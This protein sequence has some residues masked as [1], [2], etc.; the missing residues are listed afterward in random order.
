MKLLE[1]SEYHRV[2]GPLMEVKINNL[3]ARSVIEEKVNGIVYTD[4]SQKPRTFYITH[5]YGMSLLFGDTEN[6]TFNSGLIEHVLN[7]HGARTRPEWLQAFPETWNK[8][9]S[10]LFTNS[11]IKSKDILGSST[12]KKIEEHTRVNFKF[13]RQKY[14]DLRSAATPAGCRICRTDKDIFEKME[15]SVVPGYFWNDAESFLRHGVGF[16][17]IY[18]NIP[19]S[20]CFASFIH[21][22]K[23]ELGIETLGSCRGKGFAVCTCS[24]MIDYCLENNYEPIWSCRL[25]NNSSYILA[26][27][28]GFEPT[29][30]LPYYNLIV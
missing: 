17:L 3:F 21:D 13:N 2:L 28:L 5:P 29:I 8:K 30:Y 27:K 7:T 1:K 16:S 24:A 14:L 19:A 6:D 26:H 15:G 11:L 23:L 4:N 20:T 9:I 18:N 12:G 22:N 25:E 10:D